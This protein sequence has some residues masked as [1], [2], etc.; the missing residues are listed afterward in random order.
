MDDE[1]ERARLHA[2]HDPDSPRAGLPA[3]E[4]GVP[5]VEP[6]GE[7]LAPVLPEPRAEH[8][9]HPDVPAQRTSR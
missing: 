7:L 4:R 9:V 5:T 6:A 3:D 1:G 8:I 2:E